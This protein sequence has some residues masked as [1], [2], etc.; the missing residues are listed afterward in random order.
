LSATA[1]PGAPADPRWSLAAL[2]EELRA[3]DSVISPHV[4]PV[5]ALGSDA[6]A[7]GELAAS[8]SHAAG[9]PGLY[10]GVVESVRE[11]Y[12]LHYGTSRL[13]DPPDADLALLAGD[14]L[15]AKGLGLLASEGDLASVNLLAELISASAELHAAGAAAPLAALWVASATAIATGPT[16][17]DLEAAALVRGGGDAQALYAH[18]AAVATREGLGEQLVRAAETVGFRPS[19]RG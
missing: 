17:A 6:G 15:Y 4:R 7:L 5:E 12:L 13:I 1:R 14:Y 9:R 11:G 10:A 19:N 2:A 8:G 18:A 3:E 16:Y